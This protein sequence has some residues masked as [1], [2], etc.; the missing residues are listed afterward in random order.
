MLV[1]TGF[2]QAGAPS[3]NTTRAPG[4]LQRALVVSLPRYHAPTLEDLQRSMKY[5]HEPV[6]DASADAT[7][8]GR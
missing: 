3:G 2:G 1:R 5:R 6:I 8:A 4:P 7:G